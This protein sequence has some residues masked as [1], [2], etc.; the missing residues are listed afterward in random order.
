MALLTYLTKAI[1]KPS[2]EENK[3][4]LTKNL[5]EKMA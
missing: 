1:N 3:L 4:N 5:R 2:I